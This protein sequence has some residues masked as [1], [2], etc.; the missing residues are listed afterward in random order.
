MAK[1]DLIPLNQRTKEEQKEIAT[2]GGIKSGEVRKAR[3]T[4]K[5]ELLL[6]LQTNNYQEN[7]TLSILDRA[8]KGDT[9]AFEVIRDTIGEKPKEEIQVEDITP[10]WFK[11]N[12]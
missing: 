10:K 7:I 4:L 12:N 1:K 11:K 6:L 8:T 3:K 2:M 9:K 5:D